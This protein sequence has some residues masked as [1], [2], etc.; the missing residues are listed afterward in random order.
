M[1]TTLPT[2]FTFEE[3]AAKYELSLRGMK[4]G[5]RAG[6]IEHIRLNRQTF[7]MRPEQIERF[8]AARTVR[9]AEDDEREVALQ[10][11]RERVNRQRARASAT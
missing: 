3:I 11:T 1:T 4:E 5:A 7:A 8:L 6:R 2:L 10:K 9:N